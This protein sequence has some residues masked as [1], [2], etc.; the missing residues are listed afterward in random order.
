MTTIP[1]SAPP[2]DGEKELREAI[3]EAVELAR[4]TFFG[5]TPSP[6]QAAD[7]I[8]GHPIVRARLAASPSG[9]KGPVGSQLERRARKIAALKMGLSNDGERLPDDLWQQAIPQAE[10]DFERGFDYG[11]ETASPSGPVPADWW[12]CPECGCHSFARIDERKPDGRFAPGPMIR[13]VNCKRVFASGPVSEGEASAY[14]IEYSRGGFALVRRGQPCPPTADGYTTTPLYTLPE[15]AALLS[16]TTGTEVES[17]LVKRMRDAAGL[18]RLIDAEV[19][20]GP[21]P[22]QTREPDARL[23]DYAAEYIG[24][25]EAAYTGMR[26]QLATE[27]EARERLEAEVEELKEENKG[28]RDLEP[29]WSAAAE[30]E[31]KT[32]EAIESERDTLAERVRGLVPFLSELHRF[33]HEQ[34]LAM[35]EELGEGTQA[36]ETHDLRD[37]VHAFYKELARDFTPEES[38]HGK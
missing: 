21:G 29:F 26:A 25:L 35:G 36:H 37:R 9:K 20:K 6:D 32:R 30:Q 23:F 4:R 11:D 16:S 13:C 38:G 8:L 3:I 7:F 31:I 33:L 28:L 18:I 1:S 12:R 5:A 10:R 24:R 19:N 17:G 2:G 34:W 22:G 15:A 27:R 14:L